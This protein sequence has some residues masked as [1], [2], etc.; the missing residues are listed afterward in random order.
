M[1]SV[2]SILNNTIVSTG[3]KLSRRKAIELLNSDKLV[4]I[5]S[6]RNV[7]SKA[8]AEDLHET[9]STN[10]ASK[11]RRIPE[12]INDEEFQEQLK[13]EILKS[14][15][16][17]HY[18]AGIVK[19]ANVDELGL[20]EEEEEEEEGEEVEEVE[21]IIPERDKKYNEGYWAKQ[22]LDSGDLD[23]KDKALQSLKPL[24]RKQVSDINVSRSISPGALYGKGVGIAAGA[25]DTWDPKKAKLS[26]HITH[27]LKRL[28]RY[29]NKYGPMLHTPE[30]RI[31]QWSDLDKAFEEYEHEH[32][33]GG[34]DVEIL[35]ESTGYSKKDIE[36]AVAERRKVYDDSTTSSTN[37]PW[38][39]RYMGLDLNILAKEFEDDKDKKKVFAAMR[40]IIDSGKDAGNVKVTD[41]VKM[42]GIPYRK[43]NI[44]TKEIVNTIKNGLSFE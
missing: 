22:Y 2:P 43:A 34:Y 20:E 38:K 28:H 21:E 15:S 13:R 18:F 42:T 33:T 44:A 6:N 17:M 19:E 30:H 40:K 1:A 3:A 27:Q 32:G 37:I 26:T 41:I 29:V 23:A 5:L 10:L 11:L 16:L 35:A 14:S 9:I 7:D 25:I 4:T 31:S 39:D 8:I 12:N 24:I 36:K